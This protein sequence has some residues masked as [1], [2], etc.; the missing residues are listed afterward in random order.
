MRKASRESFPT[1][2]F[3][4][5]PSTSALLFDAAVMVAFI[6]VV[7]GTLVWLAGLVAVKNG[8]IGRSLSWWTF[9]QFAGLFH[10]IRSLLIFKRPD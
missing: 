5:E 4:Q 2:R 8:L 9:V 3:K 7:L 6:A 10:L 1:G